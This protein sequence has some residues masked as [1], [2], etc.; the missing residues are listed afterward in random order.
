ME[1]KEEV[2]E[3]ALILL[4]G[5]RLDFS[6]AK[7][8]EA[9][10]GA[11]VDRAGENH[12]GLIIDCAALEYVSSAGLR[13]FLVVAKSARERGLA[14]HICS[15]TADVAEVFRVSGFEKIIP[16]LPDRAAAEAA[17]SA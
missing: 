5:G 10:L 17:L 12:V 8:F 3:R 14:F 15:L 13:S 4:P 2:T 1:T 11:A 6:E 16:P 9:T 7:A